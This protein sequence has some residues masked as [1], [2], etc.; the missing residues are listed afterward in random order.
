MIDNKRK[1]EELL[2][3]MKIHVMLFLLNYVTIVQIL[4]NEIERK[5]RYEIYQ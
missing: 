4:A 2:N 1:I 5:N 3:F